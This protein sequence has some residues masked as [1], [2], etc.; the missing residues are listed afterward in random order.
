M[1]RAAYG[2]LL[3]VTL[4]LVGLAMAVV[5]WGLPMGPLSGSVDPSAGLDTEALKEIADY[6]SRAVP[7]GLL[8]Q[9]VSVLVALL[10]AL[11]SWG[12]WLVRSLPGQRWWPVQLALA[13]VVLVIIGRLAVLPLTVPLEVARREAGLSTRSWPQWALDVAREMLVESVGT[14]VVVAVLVGLAR[15]GRR[16]WWLLASTLTGLLVVAGSYLYPLLVEPMFNSFEPLDESP[17]RTSLLD[18]ADRDGL[19]IDEVLRVDASRR[20]T[21][22]NAYVSGLGT[23]RRLV[24]YDTLLNQATPDEVRLVV[25]H[26]LGHAAEND[27]RNGTALGALGAVGGVTVLVLVAG[28]GPVR[29]RAGV[30]G[31][32][33]V[34]AVPLL[35]GLATVGMLVVLPVHN[36]MSRAIETRADI[37]ALELTNEDVA[38]VAM[39]QRFAVSNLTDPDP[40]RWLYAWFASHP[41]PAERVALAERWAMAR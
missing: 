33:S 28:A 13:V 1:G 7:L 8:A 17:L 25:A 41:S 31:V 22:V 4:V 2:W 30:A 6:R 10:L 19:A 39:Q 36:A 14:V 15:W 3:L 11:T 29:R 16:G 27:V 34:Q 26:E 18:L 20:T 5:P 21:A 12:A 23:T 32:H 35:V 9:A 37:H 40:P 38:F 24:V